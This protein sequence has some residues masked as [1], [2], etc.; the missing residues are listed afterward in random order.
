MRHSLLILAA[1]SAAVAAPPE[2]EPAANRLLRDY[3]S[4]EVAAIESQP[5]PAPQSLDEWEK[6]RANMRRQLAEMLSLDPMPALFRGYF[7]LS[8]PH[9]PDTHYAWRD[10]KETDLYVWEGTLP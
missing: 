10:G 6:T 5:L 9:Q 4:R 2:P 7:G 8:L 1:A 3:F